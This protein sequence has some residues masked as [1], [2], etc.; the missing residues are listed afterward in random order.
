M[1]RAGPAISAA[2]YLVIDTVTLARNYFIFLRAVSF[3]MQSYAHSVSALSFA[4]FIRT[5]RISAQPAPKFPMPVAAPSVCHTKSA[6]PAKN[7][8]QNAEPYYEERAL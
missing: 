8:A 2:R 7:S 1:Q 6:T 5:E 3:D 4:R